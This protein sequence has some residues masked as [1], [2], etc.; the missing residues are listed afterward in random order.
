MDPPHVNE[1]YGGLQVL[2][3]LVIVIPRIHLK[4][5]K[6]LDLQCLQSVEIVVHGDVRFPAGS[7]NE[8]VLVMSTQ[9]S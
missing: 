6:E 1:M 8:K 3:C 4:Q 5:W 2:T 9:E 7:L